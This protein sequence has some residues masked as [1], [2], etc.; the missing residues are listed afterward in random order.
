MAT[1][2]VTAGE[3]MDMSAALLNDVQKQ[4]YTYQVQLPYLK[5]AFKELREKFEESNI[6]VTNKTS[7][8][9]TVDAGIFEVGFF[10]T[11]P[12]PPDLVEIQQLWE[13]PTG[14]S[15]PWIPMV[16]KEFLP[17]Y[18]ENG[19]EINQFLIWAWMGN[20]IHLIPSNGSNDLKLDYISEL[21]DIVNESSMIG[22]I[23]GQSYLIYRTAG[24]CARFVGENETR[25]NA[26][27]IQ[28]E[29]KA[30][31]A[32]NTRKRPFRQGYKSQVVG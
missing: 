29:N 11:P 15:Y 8:S 20:A 30:K 31:Q 32:I 16:R 4:I 13:R 1:P 23:N 2:N 7:T 3:I 22:I 24:L 10:T 17:H 5:L 19:Q 18:Q 27:D 6:P 21:N 26:L 9:I 14:T 12:L 28:A 25:A